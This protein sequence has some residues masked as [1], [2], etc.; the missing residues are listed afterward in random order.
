MVA[1][2]A[3]VVQPP[4]PVF[5]NYHQQQLEYDWHGIS[6]DLLCCSI[7]PLCVL[8]LAELAGTVAL[9]VMFVDNAGYAILMVIAYVVCLGLQLLFFVEV[10]PVICKHIYFAFRRFRRI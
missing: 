10:F 2:D 3:V 4:P 1:L 8:L 6:R 9:A 7:L 5:P